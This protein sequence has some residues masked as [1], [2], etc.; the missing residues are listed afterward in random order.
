VAREEATR[1][2]GQTINV[3]VSDSGAAALGQGAVAAGA[4]GVAIGGDVG[5]DVIMGR[6]GGSKNEAVPPPASPWNMAAI[7]TLLTAAFSDEEL[8]T[9]CFDHFRPVYQ[10]FGTGMSKGQKIRRLLDYCNRHGRVAELLDCVRERNPAQYRHSLGR[11][12]NEEN[13]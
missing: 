12:R 13:E 7:R 2:A 6:T 10:D 1:N 3:F 11:L 9:L 8:T 5:G 4:G